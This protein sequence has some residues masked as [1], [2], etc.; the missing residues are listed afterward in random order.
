MAPRPHKHLQDHLLEL[1]HLQ[2]IPPA[3]SGPSSW[4]QTSP[5]GP[6]DPPGG[7]GDPPGPPPRVEDTPKHLQLLPNPHKN[8]ARPSWKKVMESPPL[9]FSILAPCS[10]Q[11]HVLEA[12]EE[13]AVAVL[14]AVGLVDDDAAPLDL[15]QL[16]AV[17]Q[18]HLEGGDEGVE[19]VG[20]GDEAALRR[21]RKVE[22]GPSEG[23]QELKGSMGSSEGVGRGLRSVLR[24]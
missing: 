11:V 5:E 2:N 6:G 24:L 23:P 7:P 12:V 20:P 3:P 8:L 13:L 22:V 18:D 17:R 19:L 21:R 10:H 1:N 15:P 14:Q 9:V 16:G 4:S